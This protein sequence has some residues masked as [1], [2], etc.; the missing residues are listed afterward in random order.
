M[1][2]ITIG[3]WRRKASETITHVVTAQELE[4]GRVL[5]TSKI[6]RPDTLTPEQETRARADGSVVRHRR[7][8]AGDLAQNWDLE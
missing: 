7:N 3:H 1:T 4:D 6:A 2:R 8:Y 5:D